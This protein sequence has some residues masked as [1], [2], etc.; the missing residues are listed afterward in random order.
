MALVVVV[1][2]AFQRDG[3]NKGTNGS[4]RKFGRDS[5]GRAEGG[6]RKSLCTSERRIG[7]VTLLLTVTDSR[8]KVRRSHLAARIFI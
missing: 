5:S 1:L 3:K 7:K 8:Q 6:G 2:S 4:G